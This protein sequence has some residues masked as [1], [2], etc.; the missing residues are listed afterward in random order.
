MTMAAD[1]HNSPI[2]TLQTAASALLAGFTVGVD[3]V[4]D[5]D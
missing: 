4:F 5:A 2:S 3:A 1:I